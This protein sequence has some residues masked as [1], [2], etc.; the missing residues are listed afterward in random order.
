MFV[1]IADEDFEDCWG[2][3]TRKGDVLETVMHSEEK[4]FIRYVLDK[5]GPT[6]EDIKIKWRKVE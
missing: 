6:G 4:D 2:G 5:Y 1:V 3:I